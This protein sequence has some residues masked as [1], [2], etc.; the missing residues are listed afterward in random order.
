MP[1][2]LL[3]VK[4]TVKKL[5]KDHRYTHS[6]ARSAGKGHERIF[7][8]CK[9]ICSL[10]G[11]FYILQASCYKRKGIDQCIFPGDLGRRHLSPKILPCREVPAY[12]KYDSRQIV[13]T[14]IWGV[15]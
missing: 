12:E 1:N 5:K 2:L 15:P 4:C 11:D 10:C 6:P 13:S 3:T 7:M 9:R 14:I 8:I